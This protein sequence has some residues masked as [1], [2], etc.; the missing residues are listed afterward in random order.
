MVNTGQKDWE[1]TQLHH[2]NEISFRQANITL[3]PFS[4]KTEAE[5]SAILDKIEETKKDLR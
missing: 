1:I 4:D 5:N 3:D 2:Y